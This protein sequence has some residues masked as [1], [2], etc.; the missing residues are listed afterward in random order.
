VDIS[1]KKKRGQGECPLA[2]QHQ[3]KLPHLE[4][5]RQLGGVSNNNAEDTS[6]IIHNFN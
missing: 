5:L 2:R 3:I 6:I 4:A 1:N